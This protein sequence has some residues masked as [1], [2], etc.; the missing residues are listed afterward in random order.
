[1]RIEKIIG[2][3]KILSAPL[4]IVITTHHKP[5]GDA[6]GSAV[7]LYNIFLHLPAGRHGQKHNVTVISPTDYAF[8]LH[9]MPGHKKVLNFEETRAESER[10]IRQAD[11]IFCMDFGRLER[12]NDMG[13]M[14][15]K[16][17][18]KKILIDHH[19]E[20]ENFYQFA[21]L[22]TEAAA[23]AELVYDFICKMG[24][25][26]F[27]NKN[28]AECL[29]AGIMTDTGSFRFS[30]TTPKI[31]RIIAD[32]M[33]SGADGSKIFSYIYEDFSEQRMK[34]IGYCLNKKMRVLPEYRT[35][36]IYVSKDELKRF[37]IS[38]GDTEGLVNYPLAINGVVLAALIIDRNERV[39]LSF[40]SKGKFPANEVAK[41]FE[42]G[43]HL[44]AAAGNSD[45]N[46][47]DTVE[48]FIRLLPKF[49]KQLYA[50]K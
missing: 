6:M 34:F 20:P 4:R 25:K 29:Y 47:E 16:S 1:M 18:A 13:P 45:L 10:I 35:A 23:S 3:K 15:K 46:L 42:G 32:L 14:I 49:K 43:G 36:L 33:Q 48:E 38:T 9:W 8:F 24:W 5:D 27:I 30:S 12:I 37:G 22:N 40:R 11:L 21:Y 50:E 28:V 44:N 2:L 7:A 41:H 19:L 26:K 17:S 31:H 39:K